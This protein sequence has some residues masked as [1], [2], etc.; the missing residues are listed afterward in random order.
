VDFEVGIVFHRERRSLQP[1][2]DS[3]D[4]AGHWSSP[5]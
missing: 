5:D 3:F 2:V 4:T 1:P